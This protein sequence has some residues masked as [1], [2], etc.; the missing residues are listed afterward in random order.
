MD[1]FWSWFESEAAS[2]LDGLI[3]RGRSVTFRL[4]FQ[5]LDKF[6]KPTIIETGC[7]DKIDDF[8]W[9]HCG[10]ATYLFD[11]YVSLKGGKVY[12]VDID[13]IRVRRAKKLVSENTTIIYNDSVEYLKQWCNGTPRLV[14]LDATSLDWHNETPAQVHHFNEL[15]V[16]LPKLDNDTLVVVDDSPA[17]IDG[18]NLTIVGKGGLV[19]KYAAELGVPLIFHKFQ[20]GWQGFPGDKNSTN[21]DELMI[22]KA[23]GLVDKG[24]WP[25]ASPFYKQILSRTAGDWKSDKQRRMYGEACIFFARSAI[26]TNQLGTAYDWCKRAIKADPDFYEQELVQIEDDIINQIKFCRG[27]DE[28]LTS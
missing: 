13:E 16:I 2:K 4:M 18:A 23:R 24:K 26:Q 12:S 17:I 8:N 25:L 5:H 21:A 20:S 6:S 3:D 7:I 27:N 10:C 1:E 11:K 15:K 14:F 19:A 9:F 28:L 22:Y